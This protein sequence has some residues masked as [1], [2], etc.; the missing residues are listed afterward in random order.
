MLKRLRIKFVCFNMVIAT[1]MLCVILGL[2]MN[3]TRTN[4][5][6]QSIQ[7]MQEIASNPVRPGRPGEHTEQVH[8]PYFT[9]QI[10]PRGE[11]IAVGGGYYDLSDQEFLNELIKAAGQAEKPTGTIPEYNLRFC[12][13]ST[14]VAHQI[15]FADMSSEIETMKS[16][17]RTCV[18]IGVLSFIAFL[19]ISL[20]LARWAV[21]P[22]ETAWNQQKQF[23][24]DA[25][26][27]LKTPLTVIM[28]NAELL[29]D[30]DSGAGE[31][32][33]FSENILVVSHQMREL[34][35]SLLNL[36]R[37]DNG[38]TELALTDVDLSRVIEGAV[39]PF[40]AVFFEKGLQ[41]Q[42][43]I[44][45]DIHAKVSESHIRQVVDILLDNAQKYS[46]TGSEVSLSFARMSRG[47]CLLK[48]TS[49]GEPIS[50]ENLG[51]IFKRFYRIDSARSMRHSYGLGLS[52]AETIVDAHKGKIWAESTE[53]GVNTF[54]VQ[55]PMQ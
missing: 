44:E 25:S 51:K 50:K 33:Q 52:I 45:S 1:V 11:V 46:Y 21:K 39:L 48:V 4:L 12:R 32:A 13:V 38:T 17:A 15:V 49:I 36:A 23:V 9:L 6:N 10:N 24:A 54:F 30:P 29:Q 20:I 42:S 16:L 22:V 31:R 18:F 2:V 34:T 19:G 26:H 55:L 41:L 14:P 5:E 7:M 27:E 3:F 40:E 47:E 28:T 8:L 37:L 43:R 35:E 53:T